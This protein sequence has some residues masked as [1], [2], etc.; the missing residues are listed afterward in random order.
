M[1]LHPIANIAL[2]SVAAALG[3]ALIW[4][5]IRTRSQRRLD[6]FGRARRL[7]RVVTGVATEEDYKTT[8]L[9]EMEHVTYAED[10]AT[11]CERH[12]FRV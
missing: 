10:F 7:Y 4:W 1:N 11:F 5:A 6:Q 8:Y 9:Y 2:L 12:G 3:G